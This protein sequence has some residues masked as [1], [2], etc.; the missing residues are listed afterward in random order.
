[1]TCGQCDVDDTKVIESRDVSEGQAV[2]RRRECTGCGYRFTTY[3]RVERP[4]LIVVKND[5][6]RQLFSRQKLLAGL[7]RACEKTQVTSM[8]LDKLVSGI[9]QDLYACSEEEV[10]SGKVGE[11]VMDRLATLDEVAYV[12]FASVYRRFKDIASFEKELAEIRERKN[13][14]VVSA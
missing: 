4:Q 6:T 11:M 14:G 7:Y 1:M 13:S 12:R 8:Q 10:R 3:E 9:E 2:R 5:G